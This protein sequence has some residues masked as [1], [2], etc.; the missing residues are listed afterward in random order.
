MKSSEAREK[1][2]P[3]VRVATRYGSYTV[4]ENMSPYGEIKKHHCCRGYICMMWVGN[5]SEGDCGLKNN[6]R[7][8]K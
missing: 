4:V 7:G 1:W 2:C 3:Q 6:Q 8:N 5:M